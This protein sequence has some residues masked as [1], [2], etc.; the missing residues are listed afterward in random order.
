MAPETIVQVPTP[1]QTY[2]RQELQL[3][4]L[5]SELGY[6]VQKRQSMVTE[7]GQ[8]IASRMRPRTMSNVYQ[9]PAFNMPSSVVPAPAGRGAVRGRAG[10]NRHAELHH[11]EA[12]GGGLAQHARHY[13]HVL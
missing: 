4:E 8:L 3:F 1:V 7:L 9:M 10:D 11:M 6:V 12:G 13:Q 5:A 2:T